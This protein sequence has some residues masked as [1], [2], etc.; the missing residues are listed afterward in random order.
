M[1]ILAAKKCKAGAAKDKGPFGFR[2][3]QVRGCSRQGE[4]WRLWFDIFIDISTKYCKKI[5]VV[6]QLI[7]IQKRDCTKLYFFVVLGLVQLHFSLYLNSEAVVTISTPRVEKLLS[8]N[9]KIS[10]KKKL[11]ESMTVETWWNNS[12]FKLL[13]VNSENILYI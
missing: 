5:I 2:L 7:T 8:N 3:R 11:D 9:L 10:R 6:I 13:Y 4:F 1:I 12:C